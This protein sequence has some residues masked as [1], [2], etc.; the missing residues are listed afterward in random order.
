MHVGGMPRPLRVLAWPLENPNPYQCLLYRH[1]PNAVASGFTGPKSLATAS[2]DIIHIH[3]PEALFWDSYGIG[4]YRLRAAAITSGLLYAKFRRR[5]RLIWTVHNLGPHEALTW[6]GGQI[7]WKSYFQL[8]RANLDGAIFMSERSRSM[9]LAAFPDLAHKPYAVIPHGHFRDYYPRQLSR[10]A[11]REK[12]GIGANHKV[13][14][15]FG[16]MRRYKNVVALIRAFRQ[17]HD[18]NAVLVIAGSSGDT[19]YLDQIRRQAAGDARIALHLRFIE[20]A[21]IQEFFRA[22]DLA[23]LPF[24]DILNS[25]SAMLSLSF[26]IPVLCPRKGSLIDLADALG[27]QWLRLY[28]GEISADA[29]GAAMDWARAAH[30]SSV[31][32][33][34]RYEWQEIG[35]QTS[36]F[37]EQLVYAQQ[38][39]RRIGG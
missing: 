34:L 38:T 39:A 33:P 27:P 3:W 37:F 25:G 6:R 5:A 13:F 21:E 18:A 1:I 31:S 26:D 4:D 11:G 24:V 20:E 14:L 23:V 35:R 30:G 15:F 22:A 12:L 28:E 16:S 29:L 36:A 19:D 10:S 32:F 7:V 17:L 8:L 9:A 2:H